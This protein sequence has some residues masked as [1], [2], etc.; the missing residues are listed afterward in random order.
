MYGMVVSKAAR[1]LAVKLLGQPAE[2]HIPAEKLHVIQLDDDGSPPEGSEDLL[3]SDWPRPRLQRKR[4]QLSAMREWLKQYSEDAEYPVDL[5]LREPRA[6]LALQ[7]ALR[8]RPVQDASTMFLGC[9]TSVPKAFNV[10][11]D[12][13]VAAAGHAKRTAIRQQVEIL[14]LQRHS[15][16]ISMVTTGLSLP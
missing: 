13:A 1:T 12:A 15:N 11:A 2:V 8:E 3:L 5:Q 10:T 7:F 14:M 6:E 4:V 9:M 16:S